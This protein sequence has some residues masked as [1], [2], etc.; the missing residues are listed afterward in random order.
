MDL[1]GIALDPALSDFGVTRHDVN[2][3]VLVDVEVRRPHMDAMALVHAKPL[4]KELEGS[5]CE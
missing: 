1:N 4:D 2:G 5:E 3:V